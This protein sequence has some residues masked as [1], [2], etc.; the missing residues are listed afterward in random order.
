[1]IPGFELRDGIELGLRMVRSKLKMSGTTGFSQ[2]ANIIES[3][4][5]EVYARPI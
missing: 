1:M 3:Y 2:F 4:R 5:D